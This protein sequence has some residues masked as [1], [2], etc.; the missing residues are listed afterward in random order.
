[1]EMGRFKFSGEK[2]RPEETGNIVK[3]G[4]LPL[5]SPAVM[6][7]KFTPLAD[8]LTRKLG[9]TVELKV[10]VDFE[11]ALKDIGQN[12]TQLCA[13]G[14]ATYVE[15]QKK[16]GVRV[17]VK[18]LRNGK[19]FHHSVII[20]RDDSTVRSMG[21]L[22]GKTFA[23]A[24]I[25]SSTGHIIPRAMLK[26]AGI[27]LEDLRYYQYVGHHDEV[28]RGVLK[29]DFDAGGVMEATAYKFKNEGLRLLQ[30]S[31]DIPEFN[32]CYNVSIDVKDL[33]A[34]KAALV[35][36]SDA[37]AEGSSTLKSLGEECTG[38]IEATDGDYDGIRMKMSR[39]GII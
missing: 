8:Y 29:G 34:I 28:A 14:P 19:P 10:S 25:Q 3:F 39:L 27:E 12:V 32:I 1:M 36:L 18:A 11:S 23:F 35:S 30:I 26:E 38:F 37:D 21:D 15:G 13:M 33:T 9:K 20:T 2:G 6:F 31:D 16:Y 5:D 4:V 22:K 7:K 17:L 24:D